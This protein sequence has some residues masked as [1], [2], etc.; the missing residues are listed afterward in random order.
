MLLVLVVE[1]ES[2]SCAGYSL[3]LVKFTLKQKLCARYLINKRLGTLYHDL[4]N[5]VLNLVG[6][7]VAKMLGN[8]TLLDVKRNFCLGNN[9]GKDGH[10]INVLAHK[11]KA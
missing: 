10:G 5:A 9:V 3:T 11:R 4:I 7:L 2:K 8:T 1:I 6:K